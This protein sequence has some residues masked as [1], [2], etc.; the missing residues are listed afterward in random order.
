MN[1][2]WFTYLKM[3]LSTAIYIPRIT[4]IGSFRLMV[5]AIVSIPA[6]SG[7]KWLVTEVDIHN[8]V[9][10][11][12]SFCRFK[13]SYHGVVWQ[14]SLQCSLG[15]Q[16]A[17]G[18]FHRWTCRWG[19]S[20]FCRCIYWDR[21][22]SSTGSGAVKVFRDLRWIFLLGARVG[23]TGFPRSKASGHTRR[24]WYWAA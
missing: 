3:C 22:F 7:E 11:C 13:S 14:V 16:V 19:F 12:L 15:F 9:F 17:C 6:C 21:L 10:K 1:K 4:G 23:Q 8:A 20:V 24:V 2:K 5:C 18:Y